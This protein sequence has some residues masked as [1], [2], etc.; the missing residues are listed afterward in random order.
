MS[1]DYGEE[2]VK[3]FFSLV[4]QRVII[5]GNAQVILIVRIWKK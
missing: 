5:I 4:A 1:L 2:F 3:T